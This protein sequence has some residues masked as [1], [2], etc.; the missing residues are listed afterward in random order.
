ME[1]SKPITHF[2]NNGTD[3][4]HKTGH[5]PYSVCFLLSRL[6]TELFVNYIYITEFS[7]NLAVTYKRGSSS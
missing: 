6:G 2:T 4:E 7:M 3:A 5:T 1:L